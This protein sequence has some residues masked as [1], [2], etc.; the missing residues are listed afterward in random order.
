MYLSFGGKR[1]NIDPIKKLVDYNNKIGLGNITSIDNSYP[2]TYENSIGSNWGDRHFPHLKNNYDDY[3]D[4]KLLLQ[5]TTKY[6]ED[7]YREI[8]LSSYKIIDLD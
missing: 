4:K 3:S 5:G 1:I 8:K 7:Y 6:F 2:I